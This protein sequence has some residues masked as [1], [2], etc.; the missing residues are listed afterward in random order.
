V[1]FG[2]KSKKKSACRQIF[3]IYFINSPQATG[4]DSFFLAV[5]FFGLKVDFEF[6]FSGNVGMRSLV[7]S[8]ISF[9]ANLTSRHN[10]S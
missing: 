8:L 10:S 5:N 6:S 3:L 7:S 2:G 9:I 1:K 4:A